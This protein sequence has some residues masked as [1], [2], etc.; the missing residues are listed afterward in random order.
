M[1]DKLVVD[2]YTLGDGRRA[3]RRIK[4][5]TKDGIVEKIVELHVEDERPLRLQERI[6]ETSKP[7]V[8][9]RK[10][11]KIDPT[12]GDVVEQRVEALESKTPMQ[13]VE[14]IGVTQ[15]PG[16]TCHGC[17]CNVTK[18]DMIDA[19]AAALQGKI[20]VSAQSVPSELSKG[21]ASLGVADQVASTVKEEN[22]MSTT[23]K[24]LMCI[25]AAQV[26]ALVYLIFFM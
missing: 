23:D 12:T 5:V 14:H 6:V 2:S 15:K 1:D 18:Q 11:E 25:V 10:L 24:V 13:V 3:E 21:L 20:G 19:I 9:E 26:A 8:V 16:C 22:G 7:V 17:D 4:E